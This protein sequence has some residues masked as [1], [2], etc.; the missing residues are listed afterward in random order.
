MD[1]EAKQKL[2]DYLTDKLDMLDDNNF[3]A[4]QIFDYVNRHFPND[5]STEE[6][7]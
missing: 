5:R 6:C 2:W 1:L 3:T 7:S 4:R